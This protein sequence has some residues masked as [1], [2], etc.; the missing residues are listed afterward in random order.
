MNAGFR[1]S[2]VDRGK[3][4][5]IDAPDIRFDTSDD[6][7]A[8]G[9]KTDELRLSGD[10][11]IPKELKGSL[12]AQIVKATSMLERRR[13]ELVAKTLRMTA[14]PEFR[15]NPAKELSP[16]YQEAYRHFKKIAELTD[17]IYQLEVDMR[18]EEYAKRVKFQKENRGDRD[19]AELW[20][21][22]RGLGCNPALNLGPICSPV[23]NFPDRDPNTT[24]WPDDFSKGELQAI[25]SIYDTHDELMIT[26]PLTIVERED[27]KSDHLGQR[28]YKAT[29]AIRHPRFRKLYLEIAAK[30]KAISKIKGLDKT[31]VKLCK[32]YAYAIRKGKGR[33]P[34]ERA[35]KLWVKLRPKEL[36]FMWGPLTEF[37]LNMATYRKR[38]VRFSLYR[39]RE[40]NPKFMAF[41]KSATKTMNDL[42]ASTISDLPK[43]LPKKILRVYEDLWLNSGN[44]LLNRH[45]TT[46]GRVWHESS[47]G[48]RR[49]DFKLNVNRAVIELIYLKIAKATIVPE[50]RQYVDK[51]MF[52]KHVK[53]HEDAHATRG[54]DML[55]LTG[56]MDRALEESRCDAGAETL[57]SEDDLKRAATTF[58]ASC[59]RNM[60]FGI[61]EIHGFGN[62][63]LFHWLM[64]KGVI[65]ADDNGLVRINYSRYANAMRE[66]FI[67][68]TRYV[69]RLTEA[70]GSG[71]KAV[72]KEIEEHPHL[73][74]HYDRAGETYTIDSDF[75]KLTDKLLKKLGDIPIHI[76]PKFI[77]TSR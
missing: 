39:I 72:L 4:G 35:E 6:A 2:E 60:R 27:K 20:E 22:Q 42:L 65:K 64:K 77:D 8:Y 26:S 69:R 63:I 40:F 43:L 54:I 61:D 7:K 75:K 14:R 76:R 25:K 50:Q 24:Y 3:K 13:L 29:L 17:Q 28:G 44:D 23:G 34:F 71:R 55:D 33:N 66:Y 18:S 9:Y 62:Y 11:Y 53:L 5:I 57:L 15:Y 48:T 68:A 70:S 41:T 74:V 51:Q 21:I 32:A 10:V 30:F 59:I 56:L 47:S 12:P 19:S 52:I 46:L 37:N 58:V 16:P 38:G 1:L 45:A 49:I 31:M 73:G 36:T 67:L